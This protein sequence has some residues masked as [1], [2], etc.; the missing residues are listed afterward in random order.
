MKV[1]TLKSALTFCFAVLVIYLSFGQKPLFTDPIGVQAYTF[2]NYFPKGM[3]ETLDTIQGMGF[4][5]I[6]GG[7]GRISPDDFRKLCEDRGIS[8]PSTGAGYQELVDDA[9]AVADRA[10]ILGAKYV[11]CAWIPH[12]GDFNLKNAK[13]AVEDFNAIGKTMTE[14]GLIFCYHAH[15]YEFWPHENGTLLDYIIQNTNSDEVFFEMD[16][17]WVHFGG[18]DCVELLEKY[19]NRWKLMHL[20]DLKKGT[21]KDRS[22]GT[23]NENNVALG[24]GELDMPAILK[25]AKKAG[26]A[27]Y[28]IEDES[29]RIYDQIPKSIAYLRSLK[30]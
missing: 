13:Q 1:C 25:A 6:E 14:N 16:I 5:S 17:M 15:G 11:M 24:D 26:V 20:K 3:I 22:G 23:P 19:P 18:G 21:P 29:D 28:F 10:K 9:Q 27:H 4:T 12:D 7:G 30:E 8:I 2:R